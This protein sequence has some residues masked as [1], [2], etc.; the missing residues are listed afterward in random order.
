MLCLQLSLLP[1]KCL[2]AN[3]QGLFSLTFL[4]LTLVLWV[5]HASLES[6]DSRKQCIP[7]IH[8]KLQS[9]IFLLLSIC[10][11][12]SPF[13]SGYSILI[14]LQNVRRPLP[15]HFTT[16]CKNFDVKWFIFF[17]SIFTCIEFRV[18]LHNVTIWVFQHNREN[19]MFKNNVNSA[20]ALKETYWDR[21]AWQVIDT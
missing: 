2:P 1:G 18:Y 11:T 21:Q 6:P 10:R 7:H 12:L 9:Y 15:M 4:L 13:I 5:C 3:G 8:Q 16:V 19:Q 20:A 17:K 14:I